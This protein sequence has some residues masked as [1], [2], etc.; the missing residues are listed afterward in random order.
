LDDNPELWVEQFGDAL[1]SYA[2]LRISDRGIAED[3]VQETFLA[4]VKGQS[5]FDG[6]SS[7]LTWLIGILKRKVIDH[8]RRANTAKGG[9]DEL[10]L[11]EV[12][13]DFSRKY[14]SPRGQFKRTLERWPGDP[15]KALQEQEFWDVFHECR[16]ALPQNLLAAFNLR[17]LDQIDTATVCSELGISASNLAV[18]IYRA[19]LLLRQ[20]L[21][22]K[23]FRDHS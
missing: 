5:G 15:E 9:M 6:R 7:R 10:S 18:R 21:E 4:A 14:F 13:A 20:C 11:D 22:R 16:K 17:E 2:A 8:Y 12:G 3:L 19:R 1:F 23:W